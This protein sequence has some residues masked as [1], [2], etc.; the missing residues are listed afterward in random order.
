M[1]HVLACLRGALRHPR[2]AI[3]G[4]REYR[5]DLTTSFED[6]DLLDSYDCGRELAHIVTL[7]RFD[8]TYY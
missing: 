3:L 2:A 8:P 1:R 4:V 6:Y 5:T 7:R